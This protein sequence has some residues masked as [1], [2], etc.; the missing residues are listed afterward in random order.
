MLNKKHTLS[1]SHEG[2]GQARVGHRRGRGHEALLQ[3]AQDHSH[4]AH[5]CRQ[6]RQGA[7]RGLPSR[8]LR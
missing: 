3:D 6:R 2:V 7:L 4:R 8:A 1:L 5:E